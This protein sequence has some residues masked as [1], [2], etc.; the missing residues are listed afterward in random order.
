MTPGPE[1]PCTFRVGWGH[2]AGALTR[3]QGGQEKPLRLSDGAAHTT[4]GGRRPHSWCGQSPVTGLTHTCQTDAGPLS[5][6]CGRPH[7]PG[8][9]LQPGG[10]LES[11]QQGAACVTA[12]A[13]SGDE[14]GARW[15]PFPVAAV[16]AGGVLTGG[17]RRRAG[18]PLS[19]GLSS[20][21]ALTVPVC[22]PALCSVPQIWARPRYAS[23]VG[24]VCE[25]GASWA[26]PA[27]QGRPNSQP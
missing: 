14:A 24:R 13:R 17:C 27:Q 11:P 9:F 22:W 26:S 20:A 3:P 18:L 5:R 6:V 12:A 23:L 15:G 19:G 25:P 16:Q 2:L 10:S 1:I 8:F 21:P 7:N 4:T